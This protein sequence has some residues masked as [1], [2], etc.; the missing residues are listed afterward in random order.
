VRVEVPVPGGR[1]EAPHWLIPGLFYGANRDPACARLYPRYAPGEL[2][3]EKLIADR[4][5]FRADRAATPVVFAWGKEA[6]VALSVDAT[7]PLGL[8]GLGLGAGPDRPASVWV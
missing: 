4:W 8:S 1:S 2:D 5:A 6:G 7:T 3:A